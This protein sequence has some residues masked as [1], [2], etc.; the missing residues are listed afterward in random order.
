MTFSINFKCKSCGHE[1]LIDESSYKNSFSD[2]REKIKNDEFKKEVQKQVDFANT[3]NQINFN[4]E[5]NIL[6]LENQ[7]LKSQ[8]EDFQKNKNN[9]I[10]LNK[11]SNLIEINNKFQKTLNDGLEKNK[12][13]TIENEKLKNKLDEIKIAK[14][15]EIDLEKKN[16]IS[17]VELE[18]QKLISELEEEKLNNKLKIKNI[19]NTHNALVQDQQKQIKDLKEFR[20]NTSPFYLGNSLEEFI[21]TL[22]NKNVRPLLPNIKFKRD[23]KLAD[24]EKGD[25]TYEEILP[26][27]KQ[28]KIF[29]ECKNEKIDQNKGTKNSEHFKKLEKNRKDKG[30]EYSLLITTLEPKNDF[31]NCGP[32]KVQDYQNMYATRPE[33]FLN[34]IYM[35]RDFELKQ[36]HL[37]IENQKFKEENIDVILFKEALD[38]IKI[39]ASSNYEKVA[40]RSEKFK[41]AI[42][43]IIKSLEKLRDEDIDF[44]INQTRI[45]N[46]KIQDITVR[47]LTK[48]S[49][50]LKKKFEEIEYKK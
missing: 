46:Q 18:K 20:N 32:V 47:K 15:K 33:G 48:N 19:E 42:N 16:A 36:M 43:S 50:T 34:I 31:Y 24:S 25:F 49:P 44:M 40:N 27:G 1:N 14:D 4:N 38:S 3:N 7:K 41:G 26:S 39:S 2:L 6:N 8:I 21:E 35:I 37:Y 5:K 10:E 28:L 17:S 11:K 29:I 9:E 30:F 13:L 12:K 22:F 23:T 45:G